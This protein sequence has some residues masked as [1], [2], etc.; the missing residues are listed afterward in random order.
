MS[1]NGTPTSAQLRQDG[2]NLYKSGKFHAA[3]AKYNEANKAANGQDALPYSNLSAVLFEIGEYD[4]CI[5]SCRQALKLAKP[6]DQDLRL[7][8]ENHLT[9]ATQQETA[10]REQCSATTICKWKAVSRQLPRCKPILNLQPLWG[11]VGHDHLKSLITDKMAEVYGFRLQRAK[12][13]SNPMISTDSS[14]RTIDLYLGGAGDGRHFLATLIEL[15]K[16]ASSPEHAKLPKIRFTFND[17]KPH[18]FARNLVTFL[19]LEQLGQ[20]KGSEE[21]AELVTTIFFVYFCSAMP[22]YVF[23]RLQS[24]IVQCIKWLQK[25]PELK[26]TLE[27]VAIEEANFLTLIDVL[28]TWQQEIPDRYRAMDIL[29][30]ANNSPETDE[31]VES[32][33]TAEKES[34]DETL[35]I[36]PMDGLKE[37][38]SELLR[39]HERTHTDRRAMEE[40]RKYILQTWAVNPT[41]FDAA[42][43]NNP[44]NVIEAYASPWH[45]YDY[46]SKVVPKKKREDASSLC[47][48]YAPIFTAAAK[49]SQRL[50]ATSKLKVNFAI[51]DIQQ[52]MEEL[53]FMGDNST[54]SSDG[55]NRFDCIHLSNVPDYLGMNFF[56]HVYATPLLKSHD[57]AYLTLNC[58]VCPTHWR[59]A[60]DWDAESVLLRKKDDLARAFNVAYGGFDDPLEHMMAMA[61]SSYWKWTPVTEIPLPVETLLPKTTL[62]RWLYAMFFHIALPATRSDG[63]ELGYGIVAHI[64]KPLNL[65]AF[66]RLLIHLKTIGYPGHWLGQ[67][68]ENVLKDN[69]VT[70]A[71][72]PK[73]CPGRV[74]Q[75]YSSAQPQKLSVI[76][77]LAEFSTIVA[78]F[79]SVLPF[80]TPADKTTVPDQDDVQECTLHWNEPPYAGR[81]WDHDATRADWILVL[82]HEPSLE[83]ARRKAKASP[84][85]DLRETLTSRQILEDTKRIHV[86]T[87]WTWDR[88]QNEARFWLRKDVLD[89]AQVEGEELSVEIFRTDKWDAL[90]SRPFSL[91][92]E[93]KVGRRWTEVVKEYENDYANSLTAKEDKDLKV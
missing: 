45:S 29:R 13:D 70:S 57:A 47:E 15:S 23:L 9:Q 74:D 42:V 80:V 25:D 30:A 41:L 82:V 60:A 93:W 16:V 4:K 63:S 56:T 72:P 53:R 7:K 44:T 35:F 17:Y 92:P 58:L 75:L 88:K 83:R 89:K 76:P 34:Y 21:K 8:V 64:H 46:V 10:E 85:F 43:E 78:Q 81:L 48:Y 86:I 38:D 52:H 62:V 84:F 77:F 87:T 1:A 31:V 14:N 68:L 71:R 3:I 12:A 6:E 33:F 39:L 61:P 51:A 5:R 26:A 67:V 66:L 69:V 11:M 22:P 91:K 37:R 59:S 49:A 54:Q 79:G 90:N 20:C 32:Q 55:E 50:S 36:R 18:V 28:R 24:V 40:L 2:N 73:E 19:L 27:W 65:T